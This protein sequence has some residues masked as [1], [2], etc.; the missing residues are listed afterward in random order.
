MLLSDPQPL[1]AAALFGLIIDAWVGDPDWLWRRLPHPVAL[2]GQLI[3]RLDQA[4]HSDEPRRAQWRGA[5]LAGL[6]VALSAAV[7]FVVETMAL[8]TPSGW[9][10]SGLAAA[11]LFAW[12]SLERHVV[13]VARGLEQ[14]LEGGRNAVRHIVGRDPE[15][16]DRH[17]VARAAIE[18]LAENFSDGLIAP[19][20]WM[21]LF[22]LPGLCAYKAVNTLDSMLGYRTARYLHFGC[23][24]ARLD[25]AANFLPA[26]LTALLFVAVAMVAPDADARA[27]FTI[28]WRDARRHRSPNA[29]WPEAALAGA[30]GL[31]L[32]GPR[33]YGGRFGDEPWIGNGRAELDAPDI[34]RAVRFVRRAFLTLVGMVMLAWL[35][36]ASA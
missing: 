18:S 26:R 29:G 25:D 36:C 34:Y 17:G 24:S 23:A 33:S 4:L 1:L 22:G 8:A 5:L 28:L 30:L 32:S 12:G 9:L 15:A 19:L 31:R 11:V 14:S 16:L 13:A 21:L 3:A 27:A 2:L 10:I 7:G 6:V 35:F 20:F